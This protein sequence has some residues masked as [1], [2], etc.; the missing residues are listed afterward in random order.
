MPAVLTHKSIMLL[1]RERIGQ[2]RDALVAKKNSS[3]VVHTD[4]EAKI[5]ALATKT[6]DMMSQPPHPTTTLPGHP[7][8]R[9]LG[10]RISKFSVMGAMGPDITAFSA[11]FAPGQ[12]WIFDTVHKGNPDHNREMVAA[13]TCEFAFEFWRRASTAITDEAQLRK[14]RAYVLGH[15]CHLAGDIISHPFINDLEWHQTSASGNKLDHADGEGSHDALV[16][17]KVLLRRSTR[18]GAAWDAWWPTVDE[19][20][21]DFFSIYADTLEAVYTARSRRRTGFTEFED[22]FRDFAPPSL[23]GELIKDGYKVYRN[24]ILSIGYGYGTWSWVAFMLP[25]TIPFIFFPLIAAALPHSQQFFRESRPTDNDAKAWFELLALPVVFGSAVTMAWGIWLA[26]LSTKGVAGRSGFG[27]ASSFYSFLSCLV[28]LLT[29]GNEDIPAGVQWGVFLGIP[30]VVA[31]IETI[32]G[33]VDANREG[34][35]KRGGLS[36]IFGLPILICLVVGVLCWLVYKAVLAIFEAAGGTNDGLKSAGFWIATGLWSLL[37][38]FGS[39]IVARYAL[40]DAKIPEYPKFPAE[41]PHHV[42]L[43]DDVTLYSE[44]AV[45]SPTLAQSFFPAARRKLLKLWWEGPGDMFIRSD[46]YQLVFSFAEAGTNPQTVPAPV[47]PMTL[48]EFIHLLEKRVKDSGGVAGKLK[49]SVSFPAD[50]DYELPAGAVFADHGD[51]QKSVAKH[52][53]KAVEFKKL[54][55]TEDDSDYFLYHAPKPAQSIRFG[56]N[57]ALNNPFGLDEAALRLDEDQNGFTYVFDAVAV[58]DSNT[59][60]GFAADFAALLCLGGASHMD[61]AAAPASKIHQVFRNW[62]L[63]RRRENEW[64]MIVAGGALSEKGD[65]PE[66]FD[67]LMLRPTDPDAYVSPLAD[68]SA[69]VVAEGERT[70]RELGWVPLMRQWLDMTQRP[71]SDPLAE[72]RLNPDNPTNHALSRG[73]AFLLDM[74]DPTAVP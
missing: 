20:P 25:L 8:V 36:L 66:K 60:M 41:K 63:D 28:G 74:S 39:V 21:G 3:D 5:L 2:I 59:V 69:A 46:R 44:P 26:T 45:A 53:E 57:G 67:P 42:R 40:R 71:T 43:F 73:M 29:S 14:I 13:G 16:A 65:H 4:L 11:L 48:V 12:A 15:L 6:F 55:T 38:F 70:T 58:G 61:A 64:R 62:C 23:S 1:A 54:K 22:H 35:G 32:I 31:L 50:I 51:D 37:V 19:V 27:I 47:A 17:T 68:I 34:Y 24:G 52:D 33:I 56:K 30:S 49:A 9:P 72:T 10:D 7:F 18:E